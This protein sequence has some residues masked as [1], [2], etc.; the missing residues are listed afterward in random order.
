MADQ[1][2]M[3]KS[4]FAK[5]SRDLRTAQLLLAQNN[6]DFWESTVFHSQQVAEK[7]I[8]GFLAYH[9]IRFT[10]THN[11]EILIE[12]VATADKTLSKELEFSKVLSVYAVAYRYPEEN[13]PPEPLSQ[14]VCEKVV[15]MAEQVFSSLRI[16]VES[17]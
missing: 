13:D 9:K 16:R 10:K 2:R 7:A 1:G 3:V 5:A 12:L 15:Q 14:S 17:L 6:E 4:W 11:I 8:K